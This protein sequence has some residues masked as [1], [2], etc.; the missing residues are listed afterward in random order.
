M[1]FE[2]VSHPRL[3]AHPDRCVSGTLHERGLLD[4]EFAR[5]LLI[6]IERWPVFATDD[7]RSAR[8]HRIRTDPRKLVN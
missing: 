6:S 1:P 3:A 4:A 8:T 5:W 7:K 2:L